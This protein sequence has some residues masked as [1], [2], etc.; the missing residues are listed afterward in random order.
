MLSLMLMAVVILGL[1]SAL[2]IHQIS[3]Y[4][5]PGRQWGRH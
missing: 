3:T 2:I 5:R 1:S 4:G